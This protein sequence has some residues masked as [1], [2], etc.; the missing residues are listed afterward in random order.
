MTP[1]MAAA[2]PADE[3]DIIARTR[4]WL[5]HTVIG[6]NLCPFANSVFRKQQIGYRVSHA[7][8]ADALL[9]DLLQAVESLTRAP[10]EQLDTLLLIHPWT[11]ND[12]LDFNDFLGVADAVLDGTGLSGTL[13]IASFHPDYRFADVEPDDITNF[14]NR[15]PF[16]MLHLLREASIER[17]IQSYPD[18]DQIV[19][20]NLAT[21]R[22]IGLDGWQAL[23]STDR[24]SV[25][26]SSDLTR[27]P[28][29]PPSD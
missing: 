29:P 28:S 22:R 9:S 8:D 21:L 14:T 15:S 12:F 18:T 17:A 1:P 5:E 24:A 10:A 11:L 13:Q 23:Q 20:T 16:P 25:G 7:R 27:V 4:H 6:L 2:S 26:S 3:A 19:Q